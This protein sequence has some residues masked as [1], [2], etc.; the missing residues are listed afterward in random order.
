VIL[1]FC[2]NVIPSIVEGLVKAKPK[3]TK[4]RYGRHIIF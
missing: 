4:Q 1:Q 3:Q 2:R